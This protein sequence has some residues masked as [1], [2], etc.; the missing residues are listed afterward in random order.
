[1]KIPT[2]SA[3]CGDVK[4][5]TKVMTL[6]LMRL[7]MT[8]M[9]VIGNA[10]AARMPAHGTPTSV[11]SMNETVALMTAIRNMPVRYLPTDWKISSAISENPSR[12]LA[13]TSE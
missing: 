7:P 13:G 1:M 8:G 11:R 5:D 4:S 12:R 3:V 10:N 6:A 9:K 2:I